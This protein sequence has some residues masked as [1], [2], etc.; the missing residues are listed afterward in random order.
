MDMTEPAVTVEPVVTIGLSATE[1]AER[2]L[3]WGKL[4]AELD[5]LQGT[6]ESAVL[7]LGKTQDVGNVRVTYSNGRRT[8]D[9]KTAGE[10]VD[11]EIIADNTVTTTSTNWKQ[12]CKDA[13]IKEDYIPYTQSDPSASIKIIKEK[14]A[15]AGVPAKVSSATFTP[16]KDMGSLF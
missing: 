9:Y 7:L 15:L 10:S 13:G 3:E 8:F 11:K 16:A 14:K 1:L 6:I 4:K 5:E 12:V 2:M